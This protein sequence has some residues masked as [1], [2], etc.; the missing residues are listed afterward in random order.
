MMGAVAVAAV[1]AAATI[2]GDKA[3]KRR[4]RYAAAF[5]DFEQAQADYIVGRMDLVSC[6]EKSRLLMDAR[7]ALCMTKR[8]QSAAILE[9]IGCATSLINELIQ[10]PPALHDQREWQIAEARRSLLEPRAKLKRLNASP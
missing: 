7:I 6:V 10:E 4:A 2:E 5:E 8:E 9:H 3:L 1:L